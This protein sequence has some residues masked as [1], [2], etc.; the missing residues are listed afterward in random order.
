MSG[1]RSLL[2]PLV[3]VVA[4]LVIGCDMSVQV[5]PADQAAGQDAPD[6]IDPASPNTE[7]STVLIKFAGVR[8][9]R[10]EIPVGRVTISQSASEGDASLKVTEVIVAEGF[11]R[12]TDADF[13]RFLDIAKGSCGEVR[14]LY[15]AAEDLGYVPPEVADQRRSRSRQISAGIASLASHLRSRPR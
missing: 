2:I 3:T 12:S 7:R 15:Y 8:T 13:A 4:L 6:G 14:S 11:E 9:I 5:L 1:N 10:V